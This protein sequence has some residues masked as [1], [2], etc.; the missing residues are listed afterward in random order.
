MTDKLDNISRQ[1]M[2]KY[3]IGKAHEAIDDARFCANGGKY[4]LAVNRLYYACYYISSALLLQS[5]YECGTHKGVKTML[6]LHFVNN[7]KITRA[8]AKTLSTLF[9]NRQSGDYDDFVYY[10]QNDYSNLE[11]KAIEFVETIEKLIGNSEI[12]AARP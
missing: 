12:A 1:E 6:N 9:E 11:P 3:R 7:G 4:I 2:V 8:V 5:G 10:D